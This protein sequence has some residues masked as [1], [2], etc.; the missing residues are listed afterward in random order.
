MLVSKVKVQVQG[1]CVFGIGV[2]DEVMMELLL[3]SKWKV[4]PLQ[5]DFVSA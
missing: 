5:F 3:S 4:R 1:C 2:G